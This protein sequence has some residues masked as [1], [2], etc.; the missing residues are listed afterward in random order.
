[1]TKSST[2]L[3]LTKPVTGN[4]EAKFFEDLSRYFEDEVEK[5]IGDVDYVKHE[6]QEVPS[7]TLEET[8][9]AIFAKNYFQEHEGVPFRSASTRNKAKRQLKSSLAVSRRDSRKVNHFYID[10]AFGRTGDDFEGNHH[11][12]VG[13]SDSR[14]SKGRESSSRKGE[15]PTKLMM[16]LIEAHYFFSDIICWRPHGRA[17]RVENSRKF[18]H[19]ILSSF[20]KMVGFYI[21]LFCVWSY[22][23][24]HDILK[25]S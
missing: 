20:F 6:V 1:M 12:V 14:K 2:Y 23:F 3:P 18:E 24:S 8:S 4:E 25:T 22:S 9:T 16:M 10:Y 17:F 11:C 7:S 15:F 19:E 13:E 5:Q 21:E